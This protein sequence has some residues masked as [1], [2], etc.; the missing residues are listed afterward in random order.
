MNVIY[1][2]M[3]N[4]PRQMSK[5]SLGI[6]QQRMCHFLWAW[7]TYGGHLVYKHHAAYHVV[8]QAEQKGNPRHYW[9]YWD[10]Q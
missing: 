7:S 5:S 1:E 3:A 9:C 2:T 6:M 8:Q 10:E 4:E